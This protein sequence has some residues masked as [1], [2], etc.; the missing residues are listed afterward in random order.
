MG[1]GCRAIRRVAALLLTTTLVICAALVPAAGPPARAAELPYRLEPAMTSAIG[2]DQ[3]GLVADGSLIVWQDSRDGTP[4]IF[5]Y[6]LDDARE[7]RVAQTPGHRTQPAI[8]GSL[9]VWVSGDEP[10]R[11]TIEGID[12]TTRTTFTVTDQPA[13]V[14]DPA[15]SGN[16][17]IWRE[18]R[19][20][21]W[22]IV[23][24]NLA[25]GERFEVTRD[26][27]N[28]AHPTIS[29]AT[30]IW[31]AYVDGNWDLFR[32]DLGS[33]RVEQ[34]TATPDDEV[35]P[36]VA[37][38]RVLF[39]RLPA[40]GGPPSLVLRDLGTGAEQVV[41]SDHMVM[42]GTMA[43][44]VVVWE[45]WR[46]GL[47]DIYAYDI[48]HDQTF[49]VARSQQ[50]YAPAVSTRAIAWFSRSDMSRSRVQALA[51]VERLPTDPRDPP[52]VPSP[53]NVYVQ[54]TR[55]F[56]SSGFKSYWQA[57]G[58]PALF[59]Y[60][61]TEE[62]TETNPATG[63]E[64]IVQYFE[65]VKMEYDPN[66]PEDARI[67]LARLGA[68]LTADRDF[69]AVPP[70][71]DSAERRYF[72]E[73]GHTIAYGFKEFWEKHGGLAIFGFPISEEFTE[74][75]RTVQYFERARFEFNPDATSEDDKV[76]LGLLGR[77]AL[78][79]LGWLPRPPIDTTG[80]LE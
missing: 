20:G 23:G 33:Q 5:A 12:L 17:V 57:H 2:A 51:L 9:I 43:G 10:G 28:Q 68:D 63:Q 31:Q 30:I 27:V 15:V 1:K 55:H 39:R 29:G 14:A 74:N 65:R 71:E 21:A 6:D 73:T 24:K 26:P 48:A 45:D 19:D 49:A 79:R 42:Q 13:D 11:R 70:T 72:P 61:L 54:E 35:E 38:S 4:D 60:P 52:A 64:R 78:Q 47:P 41:V 22:D 58:G 56:M 32:Y 36:V 67:S 53:E 44:D 46:T 75:G 77:E 76:M 37:G 25:T 7:F 18:R 69:P 34:L 3:R 59:G 16:V 62:F 80:L 8:S 66:A 40:R 50:A